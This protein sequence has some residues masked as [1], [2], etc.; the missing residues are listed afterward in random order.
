MSEY[1]QPDQGTEAY[2]DQLANEIHSLNGS[3]T[4]AYTAFE[5][6]IE[7]VRQ[8]GLPIEALLPAG[9]RGLGFSAKNIKDGQSFW[10]IYGKVVRKKLCAKNSKLRTHVQTGI[11]ITAG[12]IV[13]FVASALGLRPAIAG[14]I[15]APVAAIVATMGIDAFCEYT[16]E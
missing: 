10:A 15:I 9:D 4:P 7:K 3:L 5:V 8:S 1:V 13:G 12:S 16:K 2:A 11:H 6:A 14:A